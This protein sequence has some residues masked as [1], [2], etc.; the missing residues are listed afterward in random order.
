M[1]GILSPVEVKERCDSLKSG[2]ATWEHHWQEIAEHILPRKDFF[3][4]KNE[5]GEKKNVNLFDNTAMYSNELLAGA[6]H[7]L[8]TNPSSEFFE[9]TTGDEV[10][11]MN[12]NVRTWLQGSTT[13]MHRVI[14]GS[15][16]QTEVH[17]YYLD[18]TGFGTAGMDVQEDGE[19]IVMFNTRNI[20]ELYLDE[21]NK[22][23]IDTVYRVF[24]WDARKIVAEWGEDVPKKVMDSFKKRD[25][26]KFE[27]IHA[28]YPK[29][30]V[31]VGKS[32]KLPFAS[33]YVLACTKENIK[34]GGFREF[35]Y[36]V[37]RWTKTSGEKYGR[38]PSMTA[39]PEAKTV[40]QMTKTTIIAAQKAVDPPLQAPDDGFV[41]PVVT[42]PGGLNFYR[43]GSQ[44]RLEPLFQTP[45]V[46]FGY[47]I[48]D[49]H[50]QKIREAYY[51]DQLQLQQGPQM[52]ATEVMQRTE[53]RM[54]LLGPM[55]GR[56]HFEFL[57]P[58]VDR[59]FGICY[60]R[61]LFA[62]VPDE[63]RGREVVAKYSSVI[64]KLQ[65]ASEG[66]N[67]LRTLESVAPFIE[68]QPEIAD[69]LNGEEVFRKLASVHGFPQT[70]IRTR[71]EIESLQ[72]AKAK[73]QQQALQAQQQQQEVDQAAKLAGAAGQLQRG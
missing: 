46:D 53:E 63:L 11:D 70:A 42:T 27:I 37:S 47:Q 22:G 14:N 3:N 71:E 15:N 16:F 69:M 8:L 60:R 66:Q 17:E 20:A 1:E 39:L 7:G 10:L 21:N 45:R 65:R 51:V 44:D 12:D 48:E 67:I 5:P 50:R 35:P 13:I 31:I 62:E 52:T 24:H 6:L 56:Q 55:L 73:A 26:T 2:R 34:V 43:A 29:Y 30:D 36:I 68:L 40:N 23:L 54:R 32:V 57:R 59:V 38:S 58:L 4:T 9:L 61:G 19:Y 18:L 64:A 28:V 33:Q 41:L 25:N 49:Q 72:E